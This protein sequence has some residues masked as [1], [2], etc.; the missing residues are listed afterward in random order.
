MYMSTSLFRLQRFAL[1]LLLLCGN[2]SLMQAQRFL[3]TGTAQEEKTN[4]AVEF[5]SVALLRPDSTG[6]SAVTT[7]ENGKFTI[8]AREAG[9]YLVKLSFVGFTPVVKAV[10]LTAENDSIGLGT[11][12]MKSSDNILKGATVSAVAAKVEQKDDTTM[13]NASAYRV[14]EGST[15]ESLVKQLPGVEVDDDGTIKWNGKTVT[16][17]LI[18]G[19]DFFK[20]DTQTAM[21]NL[22]TDLVNKIKAYDKKSDYAEQTGIDGSEGI[23]DVVHK[24]LNMT[25]I[26]I[27]IACTFAWLIVTAILQFTLHEV[28]HLL[29]GLASGF[30]FS[31]IRIY[32]YAL[33]KDHCGFHIKKFNIQ[34]TGGQ[35]IMTLP[36]DTDPER[37]P[38]FWY[39]AGGVIVNLLLLASFS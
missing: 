15:L 14:P 30:K 36:E 24:D 23:S 34:G 9:K 5:A 38:F 6:I 17:F 35:C 31:S 20:G 3:I 21:K 13:F 12:V 25:K 27:S 11:I 37:V 33:V 8:K 26:A 2:F 4:A 29:F 1:I 18:N 22:P 39:N 10:E 32:K 19:K 7:D 16:E 28:G